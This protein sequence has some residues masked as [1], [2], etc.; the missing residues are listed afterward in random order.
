MDKIDILS[1][2]FDSLNF[3]NIG[4]YELS[5]LY[6]SIFFLVSLTQKPMSGAMFHLMKFMR[7]FSMIDN[8]KDN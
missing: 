1:G 5:N 2:L 8:I 4:F 6:S 3:G 7:Y